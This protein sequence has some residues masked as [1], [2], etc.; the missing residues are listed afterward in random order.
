MKTIAQQLNVKDFPFEIKDK[1]G[2]L[3]YWEDSFGFWAKRE[4]DSNGNEIYYENSDEFW[5]KSEYDS[6]GNLVYCE[7]S[8]YWVKK[9]YDSNGKEIYYE[10]SNGVIIDNRLNNR[11]CN[12][13]EREMTTKFKQGDIVRINLPANCDIHSELLERVRGLNS[14]EVMVVAPQWPNTVAE[15]HY[16]LVET[17]HVPEEWLELVDGSNKHR[18][19]A[20]A[21]LEEMIPKEKAEDEI[22]YKKEYY[23]L[24]QEV[25]EMLVENRRN[26]KTPMTPFELLSRW[27]KIR[28]V[29]NKLN[30]K[31]K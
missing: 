9:E 19:R 7:N 15:T 11:E 23:R 22:D 13:V 18:K 17:S 1:N 14:K 12:V 10:N 2:K 30:T 3:I 21:N 5:H 29:K 27:D 31:E 20:M 4:Y 8:K 16:L 24:Y 28:E 26:Y 25:A 6:N